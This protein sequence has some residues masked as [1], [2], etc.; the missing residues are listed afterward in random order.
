MTEIKAVGPHITVQDII[1]NNYNSGPRDPDAGPSWALYRAIH[2]DGK[3]KRLVIFV[4]LPGLGYFFT[5]EYPGSNEVHCGASDLYGA[6]F[7][8]RRD[9]SPSLKD[10]AIAY[11]EWINDRRGLP[12]TT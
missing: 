4:Y 12:A 11:M 5:V 10:A 8:L 3:H 9:P 7:P 6:G 1:D 2:D